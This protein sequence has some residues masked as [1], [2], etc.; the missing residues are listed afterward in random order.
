MCIANG[1]PTIAV[2]GPADK[3]VAES[4]RQVW[5]ASSSSGLALPSKRIVVDLASAVVLK[6]GAHFNLPIAL[7]FLVVMGMVPQDAVAGRVALG[8]LAPVGS[9]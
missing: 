4:S 1:L 3:A 9:I 8:E 6:E 7:V 5:A 2:N